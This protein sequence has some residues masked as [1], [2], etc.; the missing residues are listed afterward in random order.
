MSTAREIPLDLDGRAI[1]AAWWG[2]GPEA[3]PTLVLLHEGLGCVALWRELPA[4]LAEATG[5]GVFAFSRFGYGNSAPTPLPRQLD[6]MRREAD[7]VLPRVLDAVGVRRAVLVG[8]SDG[9]SIAAI[10]AGSRQD[11]R[12]RGIAMLAPHFFVEALAVR[13]I[14]ETKKAYEAGDLRRRLAAYHADVDCAF[15]GWNDAWL[16]PQFAKTFDLTADLEHIRVPVLI[17]QGTDDPYG[18][19]AHARLAEQ[20]CYCPVRTV[21]LPARHAPH[22]EARDETLAEI[23]RFVGRLVVRPATASPSPLPLA[24]GEGFQDAGDAAVGSLS[25]GRGPG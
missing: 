24:G 11:F 22:L 19:I 15:R 23:A 9:G 25:L 10:H 12:V 3:A 18:T 2:P 17:L 4:L 20:V 16:D 7:A 5:C 21:L 13:A 14:A 1:E 6:Y 8:H